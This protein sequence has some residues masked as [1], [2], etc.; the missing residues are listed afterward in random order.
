MEQIWIYG[1]S[2][3]NF[4]IAVVVPDEKHFKSFAS[5][6]GGQGSSIDDLCKDPKVSRSPVNHLLISKK[7][8]AALCIPCGAPLQVCEI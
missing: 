1:N 6:N 4:L 5:Q 2:Y 8:M 7:G 3:E